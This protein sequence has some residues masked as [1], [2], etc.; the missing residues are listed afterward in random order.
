MAFKLFDL[1]ADGQVSVDDLAKVIRSPLSALREAS[2]E[3]NQLGNIH[4]AMALSL[5]S[6]FARYAKKAAHR[7]RV[8]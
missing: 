6:K 8:L 3:P 4:R 1:D 7:G 2:T 5:D